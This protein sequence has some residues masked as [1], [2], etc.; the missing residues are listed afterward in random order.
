MQSS[1]SDRASSSADGLQALSSLIEK[2]KEIRSRKLEDSKKG[3]RNRRPSPSPSPSSASDCEAGESSERGKKRGYSARGRSPGEQNDVPHSASASSSRAR[4][5]S[6]D[7]KKSKDSSKEGA[8]DSK[9]RSKSGSARSNNSAKQD[10]KKALGPVSALLA[11]SNQ[12]PARKAPSASASTKRDGKRD[13]SSSP[14]PGNS[15][16]ELR[17]ATRIATKEFRSFM[18]KMKKEAS[19]M[20][21]SAIE[22]W[23]PSYFEKLHN[24]GV[25]PVCP[26]KQKRESGDGNTNLDYTKG[27]E[28]M[29]VLMFDIGM[30]PG[31]HITPLQPRGPAPNWVPSD[32][33]ITD[34]KIGE[35][36]K[37]LQILTSTGFA[38]SESIHR[39]GEKAATFDCLPAAALLHDWMYFLSSLP[40][41]SSERI[42]R[43]YGAFL[44]I[45]SILRHARALK[46]F[47]E[48]HSAFFFRMPAILRV[49]LAGLDN[50][51]QRKTLKW[52][53]DW[54]GKSWFNEVL[55]TQRK[56]LKAYLDGIEN[57]G[58][59]VKFHEKSRMHQHAHP[60]TS[61][62]RIP[63]EHR[64]SMYS[65]AIVDHAPTP[66]RTWQCPTPERIDGGVVPSVSPDVHTIQ[67]PNS[68]YHIYPRDQITSA[69]QAWGYANLDE[70]DHA[71]ALA[72]DL[73]QH[74]QMAQ[75]LD[76]LGLLGAIGQATS[77]LQSASKPPSPA[78]G[79]GWRRK[80]LF[81]IQF[82]MVF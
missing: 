73:Q 63:E 25:L 13:R 41:D 15:A 62:H 56:S 12:K 6:K 16:K 45:D 60:P 33:L 67:S 65:P 26:S 1:G 10:K 50:S 48:F 75:K 44:V 78:K 81:E 82:F 55:D 52:L 28:P 71:E 42:P 79:K 29:P 49:V 22:C 3:N 32:H 35:F 54:H 19:K 38:R 77:E 11:S 51:N 23:P 69:P 43:L 64:G 37:E 46:K 57:P 17:D 20:N 59:P 18:H 80:I 27:S 76:P 21:M 7:T 24:S 61:S 39:L 8:K 68:F 14:N 40:K 5:S 53:Q 72:R 58:I 36:A 4:S 70:S 66:D 74:E 9:D 31:H 47:D 34:A 30:L 2:M